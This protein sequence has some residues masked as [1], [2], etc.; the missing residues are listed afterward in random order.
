MWL[1][2]CSLT[3]PAL[4]K[5]WLVVTSGTK[6]CFSLRLFLYM[7]VYKKNS[8]KCMHINKSDDGMTSYSGV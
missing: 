7:V 4:E 3:T 1:K 6:L 5:K 2:S 8:D